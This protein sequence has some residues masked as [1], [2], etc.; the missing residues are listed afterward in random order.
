M[1]SAELIF[2]HLIYIWGYNRKMALDVTVN[3]ALVV[4]DD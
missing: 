1:I 2:M 3:S 4:N